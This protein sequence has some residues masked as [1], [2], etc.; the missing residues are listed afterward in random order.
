MGD[1]SVS[2]PGAEEADRQQQLPQVARVVA[3]GQSAGDREQQL[4]E[5]LKV[6]HEHLSEDYWHQLEEL[7]VE[8]QDVLSFNPLDIGSTN[9]ILHHIDTGEQTPIKQAAR[10]TSFVLRQRIEELNQE[11]L[12]L[13]VIQPPTSPW[14]SPVVLVHKIMAAIAFVWIT[15]D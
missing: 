2:R 5:V 1:P 15:E 13:G 8:Y 11:M 9:V 7:V 3:V 12:E 6:D 14:A 4:R 10:H